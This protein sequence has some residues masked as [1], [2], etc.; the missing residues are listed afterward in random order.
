ML[1][2]VWFQEKIIKSKQVFS[3]SS[4]PKGLHNYPLGQKRDHQTTDHHSLEMF[5]TSRTI[6]EV[7][8]CM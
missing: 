5:A 2:L 1:T 8:E 3:T 4:L 7:Q 6:Y